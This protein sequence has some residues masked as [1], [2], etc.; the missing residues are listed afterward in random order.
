MSL[1]QEILKR[2]ADAY[3]RLRNTARFLLGNL[4]GFDPP[5]TRVRSAR[6]SRWTAGSCIA[7]ELQEKIGT[8]IYNMAEIVRCC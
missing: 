8:T 7:R 6:W 3:R 2:N 1:S 4:D 5:S